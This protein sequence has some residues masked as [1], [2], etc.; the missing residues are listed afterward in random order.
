MQKK[1]NKIGGNIERSRI[2]LMPTPLGALSVDQMMSPFFTEKTKSIKF[3]VVENTRTVRRF[4]SSL[5]IGIDIASL[6]FFE[7]SR[8]YSQ[9]DCIDFMTRNLQTGDIGF[10]SEAGIPGM[11]DPGAE[12]AA[13]AHK[14]G[15]EVIPVTGPSSV[16]LTLSASG[17]NGQHFTFNGYPPIKDPDLKS[18]LEQ[19]KLIISQSSFTQIFI[20]TP[21]RSD[22]FLRA[23]LMLPANYRLCLGVN[24]HNEGGFVH[25]KTIAE[26]KLAVPELGKVP[27]VFIV[28][29]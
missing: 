15:I 10:A 14:Q 28:G 11:A 26:W 3:W 16:F 25:T 21:Y 13:W 24:L 6:E 20:E 4:L 9:K 18:Y 5:Q 19:I 7:L 12:V 22:K 2:Y 27:C 29:L 17:L 8:N 23:L 1:R